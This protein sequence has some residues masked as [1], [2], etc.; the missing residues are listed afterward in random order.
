[1]TSI[2]QL[3]IIWSVVLFKVANQLNVINYNIKLVILL[4]ASLMKLKLTNVM[5]LC[6]AVVSFVNIK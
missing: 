4:T 1:M 3:V 2:G 6:P 5:V